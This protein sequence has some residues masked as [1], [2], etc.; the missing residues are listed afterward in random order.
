M[1]F[2]SDPEAMIRLSHLTHDLK[3]IAELI[4][5]EADYTEVYQACCALTHAHTCFVKRLS[6]IRDGNGELLA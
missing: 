2:K 1:M 6:E 3:R 5:Q 4:D